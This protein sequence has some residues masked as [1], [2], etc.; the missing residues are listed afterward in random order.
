MIIEHNESNLI[1]NKSKY[2]TPRIIEHIWWTGDR[3]RITNLV[4]VLAKYGLMF[5]DIVDSINKDRYARG[6]LPWAS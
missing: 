6:L 3:V 4:A 2:D 1:D 5:S